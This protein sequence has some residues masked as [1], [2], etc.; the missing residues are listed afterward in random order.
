[1]KHK[2]QFESFAS[3]RSA[4]LKA[5]ETG[6]RILARVGWRVSLVCPDGSEIPQSCSLRDYREKGD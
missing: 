6:E 3:L 4:I 5:Q 1:M 2:K